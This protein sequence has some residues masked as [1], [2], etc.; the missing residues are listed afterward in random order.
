[1]V[2]VFANYK[3]ALNLFFVAVYL[4][5]FLLFIPRFCTIF[6]FVLIITVDFTVRW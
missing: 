4:I 3:L 6:I 2:F 5:F 1:L